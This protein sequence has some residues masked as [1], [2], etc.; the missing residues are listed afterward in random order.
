MKFKYLLPLLIP[1]LAITTIPFYTSCTHGESETDILMD[2]YAK[3]KNSTPE[4]KTKDEY[5]D[6]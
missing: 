6:N 4:D 3:N 1:T 2:L 5:F